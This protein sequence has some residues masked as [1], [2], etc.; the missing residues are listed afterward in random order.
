MDSKDKKL[1][2]GF[3][4]MLESYGSPEFKGIEKALAGEPSVSVR[5]NRHKVDGAP[6]EDGVKVAWCAEGVYLDTRPDFTLDPRLHQGLYYV[7]D[8]SSMIVSHII[9]TLTAG[10]ESLTALDACAAPGGKTT[11]MIDSLPEGS[12]VVANE[13]SPQRAAV[14]RENVAKWGSGK[15]RITQ[16]DARD[17]SKYP[18]VFDI[19]LVDAPCSGEG[20]M[21]KD[22]EAV[23][24]WSERLVE[25]CAARQREIVASLWNSLKP[26]GYMIYSTCTF[27]RCENEEIAEWIVDELG[28]ESVRIEIGEDWG[29]AGGINTGVECLRFIPGKVRGEGLFAAV[30]RKKTENVE[31]SHKGKEKRIKNKPK[32]KKLPDSVQKWLNLRGDENFVVD[33]KGN[34]FV[35]FNGNGLVGELIPRLRIGFEKGK[36]IIPTQE[37]AMSVSLNR[38]AFPTV[39]VDRETALEYLRGNAL[40]LSQDVP[41][42]F[43]LLQYEGKPLGFVK[44]IGSRA[45][46]LYPDSWRIRK[47]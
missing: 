46:N 8:A 13:F 9:K 21:R 37:L 17:F 16:G 45:N 32:G 26:G 3:L 15:V 2:Q 22:D 47:R 33:D 30:F 11:A 10:N 20:M 40:K 28:G 27:N 24:Q 25:Q 38:E 43:V 36:E 44:N 6:F 31:V 41:K 4:R 35:E 1:P 12:V 23:A 18:S 7:Q 42:G 5:F 19:I 39:E 29:I 14:L 34:I